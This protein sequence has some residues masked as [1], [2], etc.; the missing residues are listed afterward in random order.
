MASRSVSCTLI[1][2]SERRLRSSNRKLAHGELNPEL[3]DV[4]EVPPGGTLSWNAESCGFMTGTEGWLVFEV[5][6]ADAMFEVGWD[7]PFIGANK[8]YQTFRP[9]HEPDP[10][11][12]GVYEAWTPPGADGHD[13]D[14]KTTYEFRLKELPKREE[15]PA[16][17][18]PPPPEQAP[19]PDPNAIQDVT[20]PLGNDAHASLP[21]EIAPPRLCVALNTTTPADAAS[22]PET[23]AAV[24]AAALGQVLEAVR[25]RLECPTGLDEVW[26]GPDGHEKEWLPALGDEEK[27]ARAYTELMLGTAYNGPGSLYYRS[28][29]DDPKVY[30]WLEVGR[31]D[32]AVPVV[33]ACQHLTTLAAISRGFRLGD[34]GGAGETAGPCGSLKIFGPKEKRWY[35]PSKWAGAK[36]ADA[37]GED[38]NPERKD[39]K[40]IAEAIETAQ[41]TPGSIYTFNPKGENAQGEQIEG[42]HIA[43][44]LRI[45]KDAGLAQFFDTGGL[46]IMLRGQPPRHDGVD[47]MKIF[48]YKGNYDDPLI[49]QVATK[50]K[51]TGLGVLP[52]PSAPLGSHVE[53]HLKKARPLGLARFALTTRNPTRTEDDVYFISRLLRMYGNDASL[54]FTIA[55]YLWS[56]R[57]L[58][59]YQNLQGWW[60]VYVPTRGR[61]VEAMLAG[62]Q[63]LK[64][65]AAKPLDNKKVSISGTQVLALASF[66]DG[67]AR[68]VQRYYTS[69]TNNEFIAEPKDAMHGG[70]ASRLR[71]LRWDQA[72][73]RKD[74][75]VVTVPRLFEDY[76]EESDG[77]KSA[78]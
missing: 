20:A 24:D 6:G 61:L 49:P 25:K 57:K 65:I 74:L 30:P 23:F 66:E 9:V 33:A 27:W 78:S 59:G 64:Q 2:K 1:N 69:P 63:T 75:G 52:S 71:S 40:N 5:I 12:N 58:P 44:V 32:P 60:I 73:T 15:V 21:L 53:G 72:Y 38:N 43:F 18:P 11:V 8:F 70:I 26:K 29:L 76:D 55:K 22:Y 77:A 10:A 4:I 42:A 48:A 56:L 67:T 68:S 41:L 34:I 39:L 36:G 37:S 17:T 47:A 35:R 62:R 13:D 28:Y 51:H 45:H 7:N 16:D 19:A 54:N 3:P 14:A 31:E 50:L 46:G